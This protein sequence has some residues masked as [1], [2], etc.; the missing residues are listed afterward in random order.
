MEKKHQTEKIKVESGRNTVPLEWTQERVT[1][2]RKIPVKPQIH[3][4]K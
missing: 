4:Q 1:W 2:I 3:E